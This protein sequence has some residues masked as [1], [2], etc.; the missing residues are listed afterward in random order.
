MCYPIFQIDAF[1]EHLFGGNPAAIVPLESWLPDATMQLLA[2]ENNLAETAF[3]VPLDEPDTFHLRWFTPTQE[4]KLCGHATLATAYAIFNCL[5]TNRSEKLSFQS[6]SGW[7][8]VQRDGDW[9]TLDFP[10]DRLRP[11]VLPAAA[12]DAFNLKPRTVFLGREDY[13]LVYDTETEIRAL[14]PDLRA[15]V[16]VPARGFVATAPGVDTDFVSRCFFPAYGIDEDPVTGSAHTTL[17]PYWSERLGRNTFTAAQL[18]LR[19]G[20]LRCTLSGDRVY[21]SGKAK[22]YLEGKFV[23]Q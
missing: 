5:K 23:I 17:T 11:A 12:Q 6:L 21:I 10:T 7:L 16:R 22:L 20:L 9:L 14:D 18:S 19:G 13:L 1:T 8:H 15:L 3:F 4:V 2:R